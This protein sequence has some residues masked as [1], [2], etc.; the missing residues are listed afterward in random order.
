MAGASAAL[1]VNRK[2]QQ[3]NV[4]LFSKSYSPECKIVKA[5]LKKYNLSPNFYE[6]TEIEKR[7]DCTQIENYFQVLCLTNNRAVSF[8]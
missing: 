5:I 3:R 6:A 2:I 1:F 4:M 8:V 7:Q